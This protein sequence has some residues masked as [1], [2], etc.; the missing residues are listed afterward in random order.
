MAWRVID[1]ANTECN[2]KIFTIA[3]THAMILFEKNI[4]V[5]CEEE[6]IAELKEVLMRSFDTLQYCVTKD[7]RVNYHVLVYARNTVRYLER[8][9]MDRYAEEYVENS[10]AR[11]KAILTSGEFMY[12][13]LREEFY[14]LEKDIRNF[15]K[16]TRRLDA[17]TP[18]L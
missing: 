10:L 18:V 14:S 17:A 13:R 5:E 12:R 8:F 16:T 11:I 2:G 9:G 1:D 3:N 4:A 7:V 6:K 15:S